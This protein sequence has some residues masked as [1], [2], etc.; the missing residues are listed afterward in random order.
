[1]NSPAHLDR[2]LTNA[3]SERHEAGIAIK[4]SELLRVPLA[5]LTLLSVAQIIAARDNL[6]KIDT[7]R[8][9]Y[10]QADKRMNP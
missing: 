5:G 2:A 8:P 10:I 3:K 4:K 9:K 1:M 6:T 7:G